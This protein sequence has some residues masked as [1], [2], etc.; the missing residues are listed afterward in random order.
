MLVL[1]Q[2]FYSPLVLFLLPDFE[3]LFFAVFRIN[4]AEPVDNAN[5]TY[6]AEDKDRGE[7]VFK[8]GES[9]LNDVFLR[10]AYVVHWVLGGYAYPQVV[11][12]MLVSWCLVVDEVV[13]LHE[14][15]AKHPVFSYVLGFGPKYGDKA[16]II[17]DIRLKLTSGHQE[18]LGI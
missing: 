8:F 14:H 1:V 12:S 5:G 15:V 3:L 6:N 2:Y 7:D 4:L 18:T 17:S 13:V 11:L 10:V 9:F 16:S